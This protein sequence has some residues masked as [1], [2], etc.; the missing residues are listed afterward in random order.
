MR[1]MT[2]LFCTLALGLGLGLS[3]C[4]SAEDTESD[5]S[6]TKQKPGSDSKQVD[7]QHDKHDATTGSGS[8]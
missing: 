2:T 5:G 8:R 3:G 1:W 6:G 4:E 7:K